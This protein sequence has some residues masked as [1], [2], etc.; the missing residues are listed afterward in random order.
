VPRTLPA[1]TFCF[2]GSNSTIILCVL[3]GNFMAMPVLAIWPNAALLLET[4]G[5]TSLLIYVT[6]TYTR[7]R[8]LSV[9]PSVIFHLSFFRVFYFFLLSISS[10]SII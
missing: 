2:L 10:H 5:K 9:S 6:F 8:A 7:S 3:T 4:D 1:L